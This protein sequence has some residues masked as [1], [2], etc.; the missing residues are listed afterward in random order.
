MQTRKRASN[1]EPMVT[2]MYAHL[3]GVRLDE[4]AEGFALGPGRVES[5]PFKRWLRLDSEFKLVGEKY[6][7]SRPAFWVGALAVSGRD[8][9][10]DEIASPLLWRLHVAF[11][12]APGAP[13]LPSPRLSASYFARSPAGRPKKIKGWIYKSLGVLEREWIIFGSQIV[14]EYGVASLAAVQSAFTLMGNSEL[15]RAIPGVEAGIETLERTALP[16]SWWG[17]EETLYRTSEF[18]HCVA[19]CESILLPPPEERA[20]GT[21]TETFGRNGATLISRGVDELT[22]CAAEIADLYRLRSKLIHGRLGRRDL[23]AIQAERLARGRGLLREVILGAV[24]LSLLGVGGER[25]PH[26]LSEAFQDPA[27]HTAPFG[28][29][30]RT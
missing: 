12:L 15:L 7:R 25:L 21:I 16:E 14:Y 13:L 17:G 9:E 18:V 5:L 20:P 3:P 19:A 29:L 27:T 23:D 4:K 6:E 10:L 8:R 28:R 26:L 22:V 2:T 1:R 11:L 30:W 24:A